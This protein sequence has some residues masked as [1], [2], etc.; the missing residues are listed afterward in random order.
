MLTIKNKDNASK[1]LK[2]IEDLKGVEIVVGLPKGTK[3]PNGVLNIIE[4]GMVHEFGA[5]EKN[6]PQRS[7]LRSPIL[8]KEKEIKV[9]MA[10]EGK[11]VLEG[12]DIKVLDRVGAFASGI[13]K[14]AFASSNDGEWKA[15]KQSTIN[16]KGSSRVLIDNGHLRQSIT[17]AVR[18]AQ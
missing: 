12:A 13:S 16:A 10:R 18:D 14:Q 7:F 4:I 11:K 9:V 1:I 8:K 6:I 15:L 3:S 17:W 2:Q 5:P